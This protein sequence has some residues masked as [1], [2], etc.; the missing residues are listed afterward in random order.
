MTE[1]GYPECV[2]PMHVFVDGRCDP[3]KEHYYQT[4]VSN[5]HDWESGLVSMPFIDKLRRRLE[6]ATVLLGKVT[7][8]GEMDDWELRDEIDTFLEEEL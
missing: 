8:G 1:T 2:P 3:E 5:V 4:N 6:R 7:A